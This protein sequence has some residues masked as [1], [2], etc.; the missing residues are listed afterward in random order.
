MVLYQA[1]VDVTHRGDPTQRKKSLK[2]WYLFM[3]LCLAL[4]YQTVEEQRRPNLFSL[5]S[6]SLAC[7]RN[8]L[9]LFPDCLDLCLGLKLSGTSYSQPDIQELVHFLGIC[10]KYF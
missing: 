3:G 1:K 6:I 9:S 4:E 5:V 10:S 7:Q 2:V 8:T